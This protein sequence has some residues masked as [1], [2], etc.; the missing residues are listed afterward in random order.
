LTHLFISVFDQCLTRLW[1]VVKRGQGIAS[2]LRLRKVWPV[3]KRAQGIASQL[4]LRKVWPVVKRGQGIASQ[5]R[6]RKDDPRIVDV[7]ERCR[8]YS[9][10]LSQV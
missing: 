5:L 1:P 4:R 10:M 8:Q 3:V 7:L 2:Q 6:L 9:A